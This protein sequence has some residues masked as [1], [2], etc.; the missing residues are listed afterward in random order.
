M[1]SPKLHRPYGPNINS[2]KP[3]AEYEGGLRD[4][5]LAWLNV[6]LTLQYVFY[7]TEGI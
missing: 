6:V 5:I 7:F 1:K 2:V 4:Q 3:S